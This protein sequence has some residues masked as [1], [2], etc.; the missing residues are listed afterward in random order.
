VA[1]ETEQECEIIIKSLDWQGMANYT[2]DFE[3]ERIEAWSFPHMPVSQLTHLRATGT[4]WRRNSA[5]AVPI[6]VKAIREIRNG[7]TGFSIAY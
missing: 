1:F 6:L 7:Q 3:K 5:A 4:C 2:L